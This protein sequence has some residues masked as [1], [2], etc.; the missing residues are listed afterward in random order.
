MNEEK[1]KSEEAFV[2]E[3][4]ERLESLISKKDLEEENS[5]EDID[6]KKDNK[7][8]NLISAVILLAGLFV[9]SLFVDVVQLFKGGGFSQKALEK[10]DVFSLNGKTWVAYN[11]PIV[12]LQ[13]INDD[14]CGD[15][16]KPDEV[17]VGLKQSMPTL[18]IR[19][20]DVNSEEGKKLV[21][22]FSFK[23][24]PAFVFSKEFEKIAL[25]ENAKPF[26]DK[27]GD[28]YAIKSA[29]AGFPVGKYIAA[30]AINGDDIKIG[31]DDAKIKIVEFSDFSNTADAQAYKD[32]IAPI[33]KDYADQ[34]QIIF[35]NYYMPT[36]AQAAGA[37]LAG[38]CANEQG[39]FLPYAEK[40]YASQTTW[41]NIKDATGMFNSYAK[42]LGLNYADFSKCLA[43]KKYQ[44]KLN[45]S[46]KDGQS[47]GISATP[48]M[49]IGDNFQTGS[50]LKYD[51][52]KKIIDE[53]LAK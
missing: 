25:F 21:K 10:T 28:L 52:V 37:A 14:S 22:Q 4:K 16:C 41:I 24:V 3:E 32:V 40:L 42:Q 7:I 45:Q 8:K 20:V 44:D 13:I 15:A 51:D 29:E 39:K 30:P 36:S 23:T 18:L 6:R 27:Q 50:S 1:N 12:T 34:I 38:Q 26:L 11:E 46:S 35:K 43:D 53:E 2:E 33:M 31:S 5:Q 48:S 19:K 47:F 49:F 9:G 17:I